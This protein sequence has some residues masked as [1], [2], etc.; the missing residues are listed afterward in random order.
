MTYGRDRALDKLEDIEYERFCT[1][2]IMKQLHVPVTRH[3]GYMEIKGPYLSWSIFK[4][5]CVCTAYQTV[6]T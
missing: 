2:V 1:A 4:N 6:T 5:N 3:V